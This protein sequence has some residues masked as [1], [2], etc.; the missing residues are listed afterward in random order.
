MNFST[1]VI[2]FRHHEKWSRK[3]EIFP[4]IVMKIP[5]SSYVSNFFVVTMK[6]TLIV[7][8]ECNLFPHFRYPIILYE[9]IFYW[10]IKKLSDVKRN[11]AITFEW[12]ASC[13]AVNNVDFSSFQNKKKFASIKTRFF[14]EKFTLYH[15]IHKL[16]IYFYE[17]PLHT[18]NP[19]RQIFCN[20]LRLI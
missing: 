19:L 2:D 3:I 11:C 16:F 6:R 12:G 13:M 15:C 20:P 9:W 18:K 5:V 1:T 17:F 4:Q 8:K 10:R 7:A 14:F